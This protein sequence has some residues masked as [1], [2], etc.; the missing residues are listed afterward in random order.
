[1]LDHGGAFLFSA[2]TPSLLITTHESM[3]KF[4][5]MLQTTCPYF[6][7]RQSDRSPP[8][9]RLSARSGRRHGTSSSRRDGVTAVYRLSDGV[10]RGEGEGP[11]P[12]PKTK[13]DHVRLSETELAC[14][15]PSD[16]VQLPFLGVSDS[17]SCRID[18]NLPP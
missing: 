14:S 1:M 10:G 7:E 9:G 17:S 12:R 11:K 4:K 8:P 3:A 13:K 15:L 5:L 18:G 2:L 6:R 16:V